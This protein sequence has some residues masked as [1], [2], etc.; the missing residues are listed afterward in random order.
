MVVTVATDD[1]LSHKVM[2]GPFPSLDVA[3]ETGARIQQRLHIAPMIMR[4]Q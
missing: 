4:A 2:L 3:Q 1:R